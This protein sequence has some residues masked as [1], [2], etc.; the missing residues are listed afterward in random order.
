MLSNSIQATLNLN[1]L[2]AAGVKI[3]IDDFGA[4]YSSLSR[5]DKTPADILKIDRS[6][7][8][9]CDKYDGN[10]VILK[11]LSSLAGIHG[12]ELVA[13]GV[14]TYE[15]LQALRQCNVDMLQ[16][17]VLARPMQAHELESRQNRSPKELKARLA[18]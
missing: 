18:C 11:S 3:A 5:L 15:E 1:N 8:K 17:F 7:V 16:G 14:E 2:R 10:T 13:E 9:D 6:I 12:F 4:G